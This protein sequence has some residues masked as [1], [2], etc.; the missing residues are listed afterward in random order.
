M[1]SIK[2]ERVTKHTLRLI[3]NA[4]PVAT[5]KQAPGNGRVYSVKVWGTEFSGLGQ[6]DLINRISDYIVSQE[7]A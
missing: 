2:I 3:V 1:N 4:V 6:R 5:V 7:R